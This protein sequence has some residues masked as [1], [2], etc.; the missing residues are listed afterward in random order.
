MQKTPWGLVLVLWGAGLAAAAQYGKFSVTYHLL[1]AVYPDAGALLAFVVSVV[2]FVG[3]VLGIV[4]GLVVARVR[5]RRALLWALWTG[6]ALSVFQAFLPPLPWLLASRLLEGVSHLAIV[7]AAPTLIAYLCAP[8]DRGLALTLWGTFFAVA[9]AL[10]AW[11]GLPLVATMGLPALFV[12]H[13]AYMAGCA[14][15]LGARLRGL[16][17]GIPPVISMAQMLR[18][19]VHIY[20]DPRISAPAFGWLFYTFCFVSILTV[21]PPFLDPKLRGLVMGAI[22]LV[23]ILASMTVGVWMLRFASPVTVIQLGF[24]SA[25]VAMLWLWALPGAPLA[26]MALAAAMGLVQGASFAAVPYLN[27]QPAQQAQANGAM[28]QMGNLGNTIGTPI[29]AFGLAAFGYSGLPLFAGAAF[30]CGALVHMTLAY[31]RRAT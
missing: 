9:F 8:A 31:R 25:I 15:L 11:A 22:P 23:G 1:P 28:A 5:Y 24:G 26:C 14:L 21:L 12:F 30:L 7:V 4:A 10:L 3:I 16:D 17:I 29:M 13:G 2:G 18:D 27:A 19:H 6:A 20:S